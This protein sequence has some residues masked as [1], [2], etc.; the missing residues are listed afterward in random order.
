M[1][2]NVTWTTAAAAKLKEIPFFVRSA[3]R[4]KI[5]KFAQESGVNEI[6]VEIYDRAKQQFG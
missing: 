2:V 4:K 1:S 3:A 6:T 5:E